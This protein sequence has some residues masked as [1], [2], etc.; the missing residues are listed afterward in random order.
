MNHYSLLL[1]LKPII[2]LII[3]NILHDHVLFPSYADSLEQV[4]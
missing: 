4:K 2:N 1:Y 3:N